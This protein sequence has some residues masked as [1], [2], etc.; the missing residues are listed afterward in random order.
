VTKNIN[1]VV[2]F[3]VC[4]IVKINILNLMFVTFYSSSV[5]LLSVYKKINKQL[6][7]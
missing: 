4:S 6:V 1:Q 2:N 3:N 5:I 7:I